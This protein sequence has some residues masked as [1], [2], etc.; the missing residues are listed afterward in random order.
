MA[1]TV[2]NTNN[3]V[4]RNL[5]TGQFMTIIDPRFMKKEVKK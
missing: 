1:N 5:D 4:R 3:T 2:F